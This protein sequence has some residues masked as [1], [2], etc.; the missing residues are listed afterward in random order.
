VSSSDSGVGEQSRGV[1]V[2]VPVAFGL[3]VNRWKPPACLKPSDW[4]EWCPKSKR[5]R[6]DSCSYQPH[7]EFLAI[8]DAGVLAEA[9][10][11]LSSLSVERPESCAISLLE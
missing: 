6:P 5:A 3:R 4:G 11:L 9:P 8:V 10:H 7:R 2:R 1:P